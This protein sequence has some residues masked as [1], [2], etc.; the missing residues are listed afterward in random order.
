MAALTGI[1]STMSLFIA[2]LAFPLHGG[3][4][5]SEVVGVARRLRRVRCGFRRRAAD[6]A[7]DRAHDVRDRVPIDPTETEIVRR[8]IAQHAC[9]P[10]PAPQA[11]SVPAR[12]QG[13]FVSISWPSPSCGASIQGR[14]SVSPPARSRVSTFSISGR[15]TRARRHGGEKTIVGCR[16]R[17]AIAQRLVVRICTS[18][19][20]RECATAAARSRSASMCAVTYVVGWFAAGLAERAGH[21]PADWVHG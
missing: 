21:Y 5:L 12:L 3:D 10:G 16:R 6:R 20:T 4:L 19:T 11:T 17:A 13:R 18:S 9:V 2:T 14:L 7:R 15:S 8:Q 1:G